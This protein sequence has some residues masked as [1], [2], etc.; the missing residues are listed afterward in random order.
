MTELKQS[1]RKRDAYTALIQEFPLKKLRDDDEH[2]KAVAM[3]SRLMGR[4][5]DAGSADYLDALLI[6]VNQYE[7]QHHAIDEDMTPQQA[8]RAL[9]EANHLRQSDI[10]RII[11]TESGVSMFLKGTRE[12]SKTQI[13]KLA[14]RFK[15]DP[16]L[17]MKSRKQ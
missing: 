7:D 1:S 14:A 4:E 9:M 6:L 13:L 15:V 10:G 2:V 8:L 17:F 11:G 3:I 5:I 12:L 16:R